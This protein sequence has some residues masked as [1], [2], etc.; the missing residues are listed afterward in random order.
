MALLHWE[1]F[2]H[3]V[4]MVRRDHE[5]KKALVGGG[6]GFEHALMVG[7]Y[8]L[9]ISGEPWA[10]RAWF[11]A[12]CHNTDWLNPGW[13]HD[14]IGQRVM[15][16]LEFTNLSNGEKNLI[17]EAVLKHSERPK[18]EDNPVLIILKDA[19]K[20]A[21]MGP[22]AIIR[23]GQF[24]PHLPVVDPRYLHSRP[25]GTTFKEPGSIYWDCKNHIEWGE[26]GWLRT[27]KAIALAQPLLK[28][29]REFIASLM[30]EFYDVGLIP[31]PFPED[32]GNYQNNI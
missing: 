12:L 23:S 30:K 29:H 17:V 1:E 28:Q 27:P 11:A 22:G 14:Q 16:Y 25:P 15:K 10:T 19:D 21:N 7:Q 18:P 9:K 31:Y 5:E 20:L 6:H 13:T 3:F 4:E 26:P 24:R 2:P 32:F 8:C